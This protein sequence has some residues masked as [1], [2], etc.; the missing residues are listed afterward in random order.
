[1]VKKKQKTFR[2]MQDAV[3]VSG[4]ERSPGEE[5]DN[6]LQYSCLENLKGR[7]AWQATVSHCYTTAPKHGLIESLFYPINLSISYQYYS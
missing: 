1:M 2:L 5:N 6:P 7:G 4:W 3:S